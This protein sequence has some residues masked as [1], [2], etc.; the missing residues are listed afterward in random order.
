MEATSEEK[1][2]FLTL[3]VEIRLLIYEE[4]LIRKGDLPPAI[5]SRK[6]A[7]MRLGVMT[8]YADY[9]TYQRLSAAILRTCKKIHREGRPVLYGQNVFVSYTAT[10]MR[11][12]VNQIGLRNVAFIKFV[13]FGVVKNVVPWGTV[14]LTLVRAG[15]KL[16]IAHIIYIMWYRPLK[17]EEDKGPGI[18]VRFARALRRVQMDYLVI[19]GVYGKHWPAFF[20]N[21]LGDRVEFKITLDHWK[22]GDPVPPANNKDKNWPSYILRCYQ[23]GTDDVR[24]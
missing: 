12:F 18:S 6:P 1:P 13:S 19:S 20:R 22:P 23:E 16:R 11:Y 3:P 4:L 24:P 14:T 9:P 21:K 10:A 17:T 7:T 8:V 15:A 5:T 2:T